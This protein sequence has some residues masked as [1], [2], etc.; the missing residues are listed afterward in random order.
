ME[1]ARVYCELLMLVI[2]CQPAAASLPPAASRESTCS[3]LTLS[4]RDCDLC[5]DASKLGYAEL[6]NYSRGSAMRVLRVDGE[7]HTPL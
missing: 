7:N 6:L 3:L 4:A 1:R 5:T 2:F